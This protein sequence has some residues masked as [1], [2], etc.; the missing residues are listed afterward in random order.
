[1]AGVDEVGRGP[2]AGP[3]VACA[4]VLPEG[5]LIEGATDSKKLSAPDREAL[6]EEI[7]A[8]A[9]AVR[10][11]AASVHEIDRA[12]ILVCTGW[13]MRR[14]LEGLVVEP[15]QIVVDGLPMKSLGLRHEAVVGGDGIVHSISCAS[16]VAKV[17]RDRLMRK[18]DRRYPGYGWKTN[19][20]YG[21]PEHREA[22]ERLGITPHH[23]RSF[24]GLQTDL[25]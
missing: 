9:L 4:V 3:V 22:V 6:A 25:F 24:L 10:L 5:C 2:L 20:G 8:K 23:R 12:N 15:A 17:C 7:Q 16:I 1:M 19:V 18:L 11:G 21:T 13:A 14:A